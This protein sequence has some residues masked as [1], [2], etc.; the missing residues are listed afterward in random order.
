MA[1]LLLPPSI[2]YIVFQLECAVEAV[3]YGLSWLASGFSFGF[4]PLS[5]FIQFSLANEKF[6]LSQ[7]MEFAE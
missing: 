7:A 4:F 3:F 5:A 6:H 2:I 1:F